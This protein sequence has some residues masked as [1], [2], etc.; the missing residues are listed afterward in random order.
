MGPSC[1]K[2]LCPSAEESWEEMTKIEPRHRD[3][4]CCTHLVPTSDLVVRSSWSPKLKSVTIIKIIVP[5]TEVQATQYYEVGIG[6]PK[7]IP[8]KLSR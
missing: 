5:C 3:T 1:V 7:P 4:K 8:N 2:S 6:S